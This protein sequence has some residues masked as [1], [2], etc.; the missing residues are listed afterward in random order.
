MLGLKKRIFLGNNMKHRIFGRKLGRNF[1]ERKALW[2]SQVRS[3]F[4]YGKIKTT[5]AKAKSVVSL[6]EDISAK[7][8][9]KE[10]LVARRNLYRYL[11]NRTWVNNVFVTF[12]S[13]F[14]DQKSNFTKIIKL[15]RRR[16]DDAL[17]VELS[18]VK[19][20]SF[21]K[22]KIKKEKVGKKVIK[23]VIKKDKVKKEKVVKEEKLKEVKP[24][25][26]VKKEIKK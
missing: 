7:I 24:L 8:M 21:S 17:M 4:I 25:K 19:P 13:V 2:R 6:L 14:V 20:I 9:Q 10:D 22:D 23:K 5:D 1:N 16:G 3:M 12:K 26:K 18:F 15:G 11:Q